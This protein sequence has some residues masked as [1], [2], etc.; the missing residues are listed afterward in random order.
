LTA[1]LVFVLFDI[2]SGDVQCEFFGL[3]GD[4]L[5]S[6]VT[7]FTPNPSDSLVSEMYKQSQL[8]VSC[9]NRIIKSI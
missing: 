8:P 2:L 4:F 5:F 6:S 3:D 1:A 9:G 7:G